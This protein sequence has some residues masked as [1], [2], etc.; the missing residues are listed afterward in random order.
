M[1]ELCVCRALENYEILLQGISV[2]MGLKAL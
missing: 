2:E 1:H